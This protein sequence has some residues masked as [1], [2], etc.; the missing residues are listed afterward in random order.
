MHEST[1]TMLTI[2]SRSF[3]IGTKTKLTEN[4]KFDDKMVYAIGSRIATHEQRPV[5]VEEV[6]ATIQDFKD[7]VK[8]GIKGPNNEWML[9][10]EDN[11]I[12]LQ[13]LD[14]PQW[15]D[16]HPENHQKAKVV[17][18]SKLSKQ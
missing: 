14:H 18:L 16:L 6:R 3:A 7:Y 15:K 1:I 11:E 9:V 12:Y 2:A 13:T 10:E 8:K 17:D 5:D 4:G